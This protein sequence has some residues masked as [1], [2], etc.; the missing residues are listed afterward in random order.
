MVQ[1]LHTMSKSGDPTDLQLECLNRTFWSCYVMDRLIVCGKPQPLTLPLDDMEIRWPVGQRDF[2]FGHIPERPY[3]TKTDGRAGHRSSSG[4]LS[5]VDAAMTYARRAGS[6]GPRGRYGVPCMG[7]YRPGEAL[8]G[9][10]F[11]FLTLPLKPTSFWA[12]D[13]PLRTSTLSTMSGN[14]TTPCRP[15]IPALYSIKAPP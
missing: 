9:I 14:Q 10:G 12:R 7:S 15:D 3:P 6:P 4:L 13:T 8:M 11:D 2:A 1:L 5:A